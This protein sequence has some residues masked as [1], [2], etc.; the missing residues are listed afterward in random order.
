MVQSLIFNLWAADE[1]KKRPVL[2]AQGVVGGDG[3]PISK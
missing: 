3:E 2:D 1:N